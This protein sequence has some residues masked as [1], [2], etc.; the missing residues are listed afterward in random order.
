MNTLEKARSRYGAT[1]QTIVAI[2]ELSELQK[3]LTKSLR[4]IG[5]ID[6]IAEELADVE[7]MLDQLRI[8]YPTLDARAAEWQEKKIKRLAERLTER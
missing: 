6:H 3:E 4:G 8:I 7:I 1:A 5:N 2:E